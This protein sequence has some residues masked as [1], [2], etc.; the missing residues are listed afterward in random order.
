MKSGLPSQSSVA[1]PPPVIARAVS[2]VRWTLAGTIVQRLMAFISTAIAARLLSETELGAYRQVLSVQVVVFVLLPLG[3]DQLFIR[4]VQRRSRFLMLLAGGLTLSAAVTV[5]LALA[6]HA[7]LVRWMDFGPWAGILWLAPAVTVVQAWKL[8][9]K[10]DLAAR[11]NY[12]SIG[13]GEAIYSVALA[14]VGV[15]LAL[16]WPV[17]WSLYAGYAVAEVA[18]LAWLRRASGARFPGLI[19]SVKALLMYGGRWVRF[20]LYNCGSQVLNAVAINSPTVILASTSSKAAAAAYSIAN[21]LITIPIYILIGAIHRV[22]FSALSGRN[23][24]ALQKPLL[25]ML[26]LAAAA[27]VPVLIWTALMAEPVVT[28]VLG[29]SWVPLAAPVARMLALYCVFAAMFSPISSLDVLLDKAYYSFWWNVVATLCRLVAVTWGL[30]YDVMTAVL[31]FSVVSA[32][33]WFV[34][35]V[36]LGHLLGAGQWVFHRAWLAFVPVWLVLAGL[37]WGCLQLTGN[38]WAALVLSAG[39]VIIYAGLVQLVFPAV[40]R[41]AL[42]ILKRG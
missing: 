12:R 23:R 6:G 42:R 37:L 40:M 15:G 9:Y 36:M 33:L 26:R 5:V 16:V 30:K 27:I 13:L 2:A 18:E 35:G 24:D 20:G 14:V 29:E 28:I 7:L 19:R 1:A 3:F 41:H 10:T 39:P 4:E 21:W 25:D 32:V 22:A 11:L 31:S 8:L 17:A 34:W 38:P